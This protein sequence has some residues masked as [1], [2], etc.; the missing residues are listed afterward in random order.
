MS[1]VQVVAGGMPARRLVLLAVTLIC[2]L[3]ALSGSAH[4]SSPGKVPACFSGDGPCEGLFLK[5]AGA[6]L[7]M[8]RAQSTEI[9]LEAPGSATSKDLTHPVACG[10]AGCLYN[11]Y[12]WVF[13][14]QYAIKTIS[15]CGASEPKCTVRIAGGL[16]AWTPVMVNLNDYPVALFLLWAPKTEGGAVAGTVRVENDRK[17][18]PAKTGVKGAQVQITGKGFKRT[19]SVATDGSYHVQVPKAG[20]YTVYPKLP[21]RYTRGGRIDPK[22]RY[23]DVNVRLGQVATANFTIKD[24]LQLTIDLDRPSVP[25]DGLHVVR[26]TISAEEAGAP[27]VGLPVSIRPDDNKVVLSSEV[28]V[29]AA[30]CLAGGPRIWPAQPPGPSSYTGSRERT[31]NRAGEIRLDIA[32]GTVPGRF[33]LQ[34]WAEGAD[35]KIDTAHSLLDVNPEVHITLTAPSGRS[36]FLGN[37][38]EYLKG[39]GKGKVLPTD[40]QQLSNELGELT[41]HGDLGPFAYAPIK[42]AGGGYGGVL[43]HPDGQRTHLD[44]SGNLTPGTPG[45]VLAPTTLLAGGQWTGIARA[46]NVPNLPTFS[47]WLLGKAPGYTLDGISGPASPLGQTDYRYFGY[48]YPKSGGCA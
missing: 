45:H 19:A 1:R 40:P 34:A 25:A 12:N 30:V 17:L 24:T 21:S 6:P 44:G 9:A 33:A 46:G 3:T 47:N 4:A 15:G 35:G 28:A 14:T 31:T 18:D 29:P 36:D 32:T 23:S 5:A 10:D 22:P 41:A 39:G 27:V 16:K 8:K 11:H 43:V 48:G 26:A 20:S 7:V 38:K 2:T 13:S 37:L 42:A